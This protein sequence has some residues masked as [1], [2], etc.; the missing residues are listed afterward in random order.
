MKWINTTLL[1]DVM[2]LEW[3]DRERS[4]F[5]SFRSGNQPELIVGSNNQDCS[6]HILRSLPP[7]IPP[8]PSSDFL[9]TPCLSIESLREMFSYS[10]E[11]DFAIW[12][13]RVPS[14]TANQTNG[15]HGLS[16]SCH[17]TS[18]WCYFTVPIIGC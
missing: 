1:R 9:T 10:T 5:P 17:P 13:R 15:E 16:S 8:Y 12:C 7:P 4:H 3:H 2:G 11:V 14:C 18:I 6:H